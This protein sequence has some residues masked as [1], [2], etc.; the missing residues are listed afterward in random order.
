MQNI[1]MPPIFNDFEREK[2]N[3][4]TIVIK[5]SNR[6][7]AFICSSKQSVDVGTNLPDEN[8]SEISSNQNEQSFC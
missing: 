3:M 2:N 6:V 4:S 8:K 7:K 5:K 1:R